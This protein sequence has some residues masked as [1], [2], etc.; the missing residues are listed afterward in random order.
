MHSPS[1][2]R[3]TSSVLARLFGLTG[4]ELRLPKVGLDT[5]LT[6]VALRRQRRQLK[7]L[8]AHLLRDIGLE[9]DEADSEARRPVWDVPSNWKL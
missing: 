1:P 6:L 3:P 2:S 9:P 8:D 7:S 4:A 5:V